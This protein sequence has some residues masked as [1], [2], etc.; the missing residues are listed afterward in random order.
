MPDTTPTE[1]HDRIAQAL[2]DALKPRYAGPQHN[3]PGGLPLTA[4]AEEIR[5][6]RAQPLADAVLAVLPHTELVLGTTDQQPETAPAPLSEVWTV[7]HEDESVWAHFATVDAARQ[8]TI[9]CWQEDE[10]SCPDYSWRQDGPRLELLV[11]GEHS[12]VYASRHRVYGTPETTPADRRARWEA[13]AH[14]AG[15]EVDRNTLAVYMAVADAEQQELRDAVSGYRRTLAEAD[16]RKQEYK[17]ACIRLRAEVERLR[18]D[19]AAVLR[20]AANA[21]VAGPVDSRVSA[22]AAFTEAIELLRRMADE[23]QQP[24]TIGL[25]AH[26]GDPRETHHHGYVRTPH[27]DDEAQQPETEA[28]DPVNI[29]GVATG[30]ACGE[31]CVARVRGR[32]PEHAHCRAVL[33]QPDTET[34]APP[35][36]VGDRYECRTRARTVTV[37]R[38]WVDKYSG[39]TVAFEWHGGMSGAAHSVDMFHQ[40]YHPAP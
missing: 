10:P 19:R 1:L 2:A 15:R 29:L 11:G 3:S 39:D 26:C 8:G 24:D 40:L 18:T 21:L 7:W 5:L 38:L 32:T 31:C 30:G 20:E 34:E 13:A 37:T 27:A 14:A 22:A 25:C 35:L 36:A 33:D 6:H 4:T 16:Q 9:D 17:Q 12:G 23:A 28:A